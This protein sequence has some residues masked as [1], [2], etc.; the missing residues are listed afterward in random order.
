MYH[1]EKRTCHA[2]RTCRNHCL[3]SL[4]VQVRDVFLSV[5]A[6]IADTPYLVQRPRYVTS[7]VGASSRGVNI[8]LVFLSNLVTISQETGQNSWRFC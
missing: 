2:C 4:N 3:R 5:A 1:N 8:V 6:I 7:V